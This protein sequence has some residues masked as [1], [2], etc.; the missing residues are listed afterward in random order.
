MQSFVTSCA[1]CGVCLLI[2]S[3]RATSWSL[4]LLDYSTA[5]DS[6]YVINLPPFVVVY[7]ASVA[8]SAVFGFVCFEQLLIKSVNIFL[9]STVALVV[10]VSEICKLHR[11]D[12]WGEVVFQILLMNNI[13]HLRNN[14][15][16]LFFKCK[17]EKPESVYNSSDLF[18]FSCL[19][20]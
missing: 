15:S 10:F 7:F 18:F 11:K 17:W 20:K 3:L 12:G 1:A 8:F 6:S 14:T 5:D 19:F 4:L 16:S 13:L 2:S 9:H